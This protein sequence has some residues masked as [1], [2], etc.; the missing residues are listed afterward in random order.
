MR[1][2]QEQSA[3]PTIIHHCRLRISPAVHTDSP[4]WSQ[5][6]LTRWCM[7]IGDYTQ[8]HSGMALKDSS[9]GKS[10]TGHISG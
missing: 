10:S 8:H 1:K 2:L 9:E 7:S 6:D 5:E 4:L 3:V